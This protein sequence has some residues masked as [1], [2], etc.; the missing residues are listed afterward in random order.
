MAARIIL[1][2]MTFSPD[3]N[4]GGRL[5]S[6]SDLTTALD[7]FSARGY[8]ELNTAR[9]QGGWKERGFT[10]GTKVFPQYAG[11]HGPET[12]TAAFKTSL[13]ELG[14]DC[15]FYH[16]APD[17][18]TPF[19]TTLSTLNNLHRAGKFRRLGLSNFSAFKLAEIVTTCHA[20]NWIRIESGLLPACRR[21]GIDFIA[22]STIVASLLSG[23]VFQGVGLCGGGGVWLVHHS[24][25][26]VSRW[27][28]IILG[29]SK[30][31]Q[32][33]GSMDALERGQ[34][35]G[36]MLE[37]VERVGRTARVDDRPFR[38]GEPYGYETAEVLFGEGEDE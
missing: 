8:T 35:D 32:L 5:L 4:A 22:Y 9:T 38:Y 7:K 26:D 24:R 36:E 14:T 34:L 21:Y 11:A 16:H 19:T 15:I 23:P 33:E 10:I 20:N 13:T 12:L 31:G 28:G 1:G 2:L 27:D 6:V 17:R 25:I 18:Y 3:V 30:L 37:E 29:V